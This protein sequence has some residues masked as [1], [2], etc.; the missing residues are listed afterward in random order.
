MSTETSSNW[1]RGND[2]E[3][4]NKGRINDRPGSADAKDQ[5]KKDAKFG[6]LGIIY[7]GIGPKD[8]DTGIPTAL[9]NV[10]LLTF[11]NVILILITAVAM[12]LPTL[13]HM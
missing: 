13:S 4:T 3:R 8:E 11:R 1:R 12:N 6:K 5:S 9:R 10:R 7:Q 2:N